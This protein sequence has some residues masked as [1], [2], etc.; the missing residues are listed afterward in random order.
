[1]WLRIA[2]VLVF[3]AACFGRL[4]ADI[5]GDGVVNWG[6]FFDIGQ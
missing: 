6:R 1:V 4:R 2:L 3:A 5:D